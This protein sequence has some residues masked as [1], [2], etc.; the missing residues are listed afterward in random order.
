M[1]GGMDGRMDSSCD[2]SDLPLCA[3]ASRTISISSHLSIYLSIYLSAY[4]SRH[5]CASI[6]TCVSTP[7]MSLCVCSG[8]SPLSTK[9]G[10]QRVSLIDG[11]VHLTSLSLSRSVSLTLCFPIRIV[12]TAPPHI[13]PKAARPCMPRLSLAYRSTSYVSALR[14]RGMLAWWPHPSTCQGD[15]SCFW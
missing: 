5:Q 1:D 6:P 14:L 7:A 15:G 12:F 10:W 2:I 13:R 3:S 11:L 9:M 8:K 4:L